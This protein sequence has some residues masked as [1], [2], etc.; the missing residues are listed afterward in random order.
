MIKVVLKNKNNHP[1]IFG[2]CLDDGMVFEKITDIAPKSESEILARA[3]RY[4]KNLVFEKIK[5]KEVK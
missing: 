1:V 3:K 5:Q 4:E 2:R